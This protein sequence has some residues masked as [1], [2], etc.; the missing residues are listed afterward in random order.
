VQLENGDQGKKQF[1]LILFLSLLTGAIEIGINFSTLMFY[2]RS[3]GGTAATFSW[4]LG[5]FGA[6]LFISS[7]I[8]GTLSDRYGRKPVLILICGGSIF[9]NAL[10]L[11]ANSLGAVV[12]ARLLTGLF[13]ATPTILTTMAVDQQKTSSHSQIVR[14]SWIEAA[15]SIGAL[16]IGPL[17]GG[18]A[19]LYDIR[20]PYYISLLSATIRVALILVF[21]KETKLS[22]S[23]VKVK[24]NLKNIFGDISLVRGS[25]ALKGVATIAMLFGLG[26]AVREVSVAYFLKDRAGLN[27]ASI[28]SF[29]SLQGC[30][31]VLVQLF[32][33]SFLSKRVSEIRLLALSGA[34]IAGTMLLLISTT[35]PLLIGIHYV[36]FGFGYSF[37]FP[38]LGSIAAKATTDENRGAAMSLL[39][40]GF[41]FGRMA[42]P[43]FGYAYDQI[44]PFAPLTFGLF[45]FAAI[46]VVALIWRW[47]SS[48]TS[49]DMIDKIGA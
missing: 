2:V 10:L 5:G 8:W 36:I 21:I 34:M 47:T 6:L 26:V 41:N 45:V 3:F 39:R 1:Y 12:C 38:V 37:P 7:P 27:T 9:A 25:L 30:V 23:N 44:S 42:A 28:G 16:A 19:A 18:F 33:I 29:Q 13:G 49:N 11:F 24:F 43:A 32:V 31:M 35:D 14:L 4:M 15:Y 48:K 46:P 22:F 40:S 17:I 20:G